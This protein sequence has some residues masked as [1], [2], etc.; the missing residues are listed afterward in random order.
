MLN[1]LKELAGRKQKKEKK[2]KEKQLRQSLA[3]KCN[4]MGSEY[5]SHGEDET[6]YTV[7]TINGESIRLKKEEITIMSVTN[8]K[9]KK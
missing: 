3:E 6:E 9:Q 1:T 5:A 7:V 4:Q 2:E 8:Y